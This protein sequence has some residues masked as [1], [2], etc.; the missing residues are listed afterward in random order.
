MRGRIPPQE[1]DYCVNNV[2][3]MNGLNRRR[4]RL[5]GKSG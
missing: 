5:R 1:V 3:K 4:V 2:I